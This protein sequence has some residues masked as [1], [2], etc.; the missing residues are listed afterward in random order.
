M[1]ARS[2]LLAAWVL[3]ACSPTPDARPAS[4]V[5]GPLSPASAS[6]TPAGAAPRRACSHKGYAAPA[7][8]KP[9]ISVAARG[10]LLDVTFENHGT[11]P[12]C[13]LTHVATTGEHF[14][15]I[16][17][18]VG[19]GP[20]PT[21]SLTFVDDR[22]ESSPVSFEIAPGGRL[23]KTIDLGAWAKRRMNGSR[24][25]ASG[26]YTVSLTYDSSRETT[27]WPG[28]LHATTTMR[29]P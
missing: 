19:G 4:G 3:G 8:A 1:S 23:T 17:V 9:A 10:T 24:A 15:W 18:E 12:V 22:R 13:M 21:R 29:V 28:T 27:A 11:E 16:T 7:E 26:G 25:L 6:P 2:W 20:G 5:A 14:D